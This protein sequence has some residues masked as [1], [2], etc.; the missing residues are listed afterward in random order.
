MSRS[1]FHPQHPAKVLLDVFDL[2]RRG[3]TRTLA[4]SIV[5]LDFPEEDSARIEQLNTKSNEGTL[6]DEEADRVGRVC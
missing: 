1:P 3:M 6:T 5:A 2:S 4:E